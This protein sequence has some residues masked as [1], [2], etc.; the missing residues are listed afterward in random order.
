MTDNKSVEYKINNVVYK[1]DFNTYINIL[2]EFK[3]AYGINIDSN[4]STFL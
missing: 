2:K 4:I 1:Y 3:R